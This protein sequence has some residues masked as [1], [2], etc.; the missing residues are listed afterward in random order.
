M[1]E[2]S[3]PGAITPPLMSNRIASSTVMGNSTTVLRGATSTY[4]LNAVGLLGTN[5]VTMS[6]PVESLSAFNCSYDFC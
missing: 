6:S 5:T 3:A 2:L 1:L 4:P